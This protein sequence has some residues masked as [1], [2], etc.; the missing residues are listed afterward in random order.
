[1]QSGGNW[2]ATGIHTQGL[3]WNYKHAWQDGLPKQITE[4]LG[5]QRLRY[6]FKEQTVVCCYINAL[7]AKYSTFKWCTN[8][9]FLN[10]G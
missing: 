4:K 10:C 9:D 5:I 2:L 8:L 3:T 7:N 6:F 1:M